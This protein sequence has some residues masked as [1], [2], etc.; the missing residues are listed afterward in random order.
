MCA[1]DLK[2]MLLDED[3]IT[4]FEPI[5]KS[6]S[7]NINELIHLS[8]INL[9]LDPKSYSFNNESDPKSH[10]SK[11][12]YGMASSSKTGTSSF[13]TYKTDTSLSNTDLSN[14]CPSSRTED[15]IDNAIILS[16]IS[17]KEE[18]T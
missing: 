1:L 6:Y 13:K 9:E 11:S 16:D 15:C 5:S 17:I 14:I 7:F 12:D 2:D 10:P 18:G 8:N 3:V 4:N